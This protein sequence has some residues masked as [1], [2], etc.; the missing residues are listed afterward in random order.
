MRHYSQSSG[1]GGD[2]KLCVAELTDH[3][4]VMLCDHRLV[5]A[6]ASWRRL[7]RMGVETCSCCTEW[8]SDSAVIRVE[9]APHRRRLFHL[10]RAELAPT[11]QSVLFEPA[12]ESKV[13]SLAPGE[14]IL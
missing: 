6:L 7:D 14:C 9:V 12:H 5:L 1:A 13:Q 4:G 2:R 8:T 10:V 3:T 11:A